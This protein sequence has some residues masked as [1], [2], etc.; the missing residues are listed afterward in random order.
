MMRKYSNQTIHMFYET[1]AFLLMIQFPPFLLWRPW[2][3]N[4][5]HTVWAQLTDTSR[6]FGTWFLFISEIMVSVAASDGRMLIIHD[7]I[8]GYDRCATYLYSNVCV[9]T[10]AGE[11]ILITNNQKKP[12]FWCI[13]VHLASFFYLPLHF[14]IFY[15]TL[16]K[17][18]CVCVCVYTEGGQCWYD[19][20]FRQWSVCLWWG[21]RT[22]PMVLI[23]GS[24]KPASVIYNSTPLCVFFIKS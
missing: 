12:V 19:F 17:S 2:S 13:L 18:L 23:P 8:K 4:I 6:S 24:W 14:Y 22:C 20:F 16:L 11:Q 10:A 21:M 9:W 15:N 5:T 1:L 7:R 3:F